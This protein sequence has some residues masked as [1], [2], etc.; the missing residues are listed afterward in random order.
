MEKDNNIQDEAAHI[1]AQYIKYL[2]NQLYIATVKLASAEHAC[3]AYRDVIGNLCE[4]ICGG[5]N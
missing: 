3:N 2:E 5:N 1:D 4:S